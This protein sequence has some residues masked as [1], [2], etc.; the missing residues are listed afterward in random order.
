VPSTSQIATFAPEA[1]NRSQWRVR[2][3][4]PHP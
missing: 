4:E 2:C 3:R 1:E